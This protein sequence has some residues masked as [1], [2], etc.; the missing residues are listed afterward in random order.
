M[1]V[2]SLGRLGV[3]DAD[4]HGP[5]VG[6]EGDALGSVSLVIQGVRSQALLDL[7]SHPV[8][9]GDVVGAREASGDRQP[10]YAREVSRRC[11]A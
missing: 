10:G 6:H 2:G 8:R 11:A 3:A 9:V 7:V 4:L 1:R 5:F